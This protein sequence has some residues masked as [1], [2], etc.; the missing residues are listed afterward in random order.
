MG[1]YFKSYELKQMNDMNR[2]KNDDLFNKSKKLG[3][4]IIPISTSEN[5]IDPLMK[6]FKKRGEK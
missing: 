1:G 6:F 4:D 2:K 3:I 5:Y